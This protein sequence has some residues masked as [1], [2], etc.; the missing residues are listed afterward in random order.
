MKT[1]LPYIQIAGVIQLVIASANIVLPKKLEYGANIARMSNICR[2]VFVVH[3]IYIGGLLVALGALC[4]AFAPDLAGASP[5]GR[6]LTVFLAV[7]WGARIFIQLFYYDATVKRENPLGHI[8]F[9]TLFVFLTGVFTLT[10][11]EIAK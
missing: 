7:F 6:S 1:M 10:A 5:L 8:F 11:L 9:L 2:Q 4:L 3:S